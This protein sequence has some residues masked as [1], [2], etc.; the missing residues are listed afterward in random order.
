MAAR[1]VIDTSGL[2][3]LAPVAQAL[4]IRLRKT[5][6]LARIRRISFGEAP[7]AEV[8][9]RGGFDLERVL[10]SRPAS[11]ATLCRINCAVVLAV[12]RR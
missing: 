11:S 12:V 3:D 6:P 1:I 7:A 4:A 2:A 9:D 10:Q 8:L 5:N